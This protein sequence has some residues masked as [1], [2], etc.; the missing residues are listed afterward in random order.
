MATKETPPYPSGTPVEWV[1]SETTGPGKAIVFQGHHLRFEPDPRFL[2]AKGKPRRLEWIRDLTVI[3]QL[4]GAT[5]NRGTRPVFR[6]AQDLIEQSRE[7]QF[8]TQ[9][10]EV[11]A[12][13]F[14]T[15]ATFKTE[16]QALYKRLERLEKGLTEPP[17]AESE[18]PSPRRRPPPK[19]S[20]EDDE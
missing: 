3:D 9:L 6:I 20:L 12:G 8:R 16:L 18:S 14:V 7:E 10:K 19:G 15:E 4:T 1:W 5:Y 2:T 11:G 13:C 17:K